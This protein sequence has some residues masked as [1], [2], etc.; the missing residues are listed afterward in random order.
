MSSLQEP[1]NKKPAAAKKPKAEAPVEAAPKPKVAIP[2]MEELIVSTEGLA[3][4]VSQFVS[5]A[6]G[7]I[8]EE[9]L[10][11]LVSCEKRQAGEAGRKGGGEESGAGR[12]MVHGHVPCLGESWVECR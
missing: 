4:K 5:Q 12:S 1:K 3:A 8:V 11:S 9:K 10:R 6:R 7:A 2:A